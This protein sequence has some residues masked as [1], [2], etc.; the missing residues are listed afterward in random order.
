MSAA[1]AFATTALTQLGRVVDEQ[2]ENI[3]AGGAM[4]A[5]ALAAGGILHAYGTGHSRSVAL[6]LVARAGGFI[7]TNLLSIKDLV[8]W[9]GQAPESIRDPRLEREPGVAEAV[10]ALHDVRA[11]DVMVIASNSGMNPAIVEMARLVRD[12]GVP[13][14]AVGS[15]AHSRAVASRDTTGTTLFDNA[16]VVVDTLTPHG[17]AVVALETGG[18]ACGTST[19]GGVLIA[20]LLVARAIEEL[21][22]RQV[23]V[24]VYRSMNTSGA[25]TS[26]AE[27]EQSWAARLRPV[28]A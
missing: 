18:Y 26:N 9:G 16:D 21:D 1:D 17:D 24:P 10:L 14:V 15:L 11:G 20:Q 8:L 6:E 25:D 7:P 23:H 2:R 28:E 13:V 19:L 27:A 4:I 12:R 22:R 5:A 3:A